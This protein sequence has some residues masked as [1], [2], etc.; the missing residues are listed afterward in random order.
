MVCPRARL[1]ALAS[2]RSQRGTDG[3]PCPGGPAPGRVLPPQPGARHRDRRV[4]IENLEAMRFGEEVLREASWNPLSYVYL[5]GGGLF[6]LLAREFA[7]LPDRLRSAAARMRSL[8]AALDAAR[9]TLA[10]GGER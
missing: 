8:P 7:P 3:F 9:A 1:L 4:L 10:A 5:F 6:A 2:A